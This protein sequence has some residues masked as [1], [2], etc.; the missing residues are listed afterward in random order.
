MPSE[1]RIFDPGDFDDGSPE[2]DL[3]EV[4]LTDDAWETIALPDDLLMLADQLRC[5]ASRLHESHGADQ[6]QR[7][8]LRPERAER[9]ET[10]L[11]TAKASAW[12]P[13][14]W[15]L[16]VALITAVLVWNG[17]QATPPTPAAPT[18][19]VTPSVA[20]HIDFGP[21][22]GG[23]IHQV[24]LPAP[25]PT[26]QGPNAAELDALLD[27]MQNETTSVAVSL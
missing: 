1:P 3:P 19:A 17:R 13:L 6:L 8:L 15:M 26:Q 24:S 12:L 27:L 21:D 16:P 5:D 7:E 11:P 18:V 2:L 23:G 10:V 22:F 14:L 20:P 9:V 25:P 4:D